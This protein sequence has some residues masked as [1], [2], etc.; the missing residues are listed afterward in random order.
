MLIHIPLQGDPMRVAGVA[1]IVISLNSIGEATLKTYFFD[2]LDSALIDSDDT[3]KIHRNIPFLLAELR[4]QLALGR[5]LTVAES[6][7]LKPACFQRA[8]GSLVTE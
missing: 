2:R 7:Q 8:A 4:E 3:Q 1:H 5:R 6:E